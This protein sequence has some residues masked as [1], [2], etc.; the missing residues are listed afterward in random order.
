MALTSNQQLRYNRHLIH[1]GIGE[2]GQERLLRAK[3]L[4]VGVGGLGSPIALY[5]AAAGVG[6]LGLVDGDT[7]SISNLQ[8]QVLYT[9]A[10]VGKPKT[11]CAAQ[12]LRSLN[13]DVTVNTYQCM[14]TAENAEEIIK[15][16]D[17][18][19]DGTDNFDVR[20]LISDTCERLSKPYV[21]GAIRAMEGQVA[22]LCK[23]KATYRTLM[24]AE[25]VTEEMSNPD[26]S[27]V[28]TT[29]AIVGSIEA[30]QVIQLI[31]G[32]GDPL[33]DRLCTIDLST[34][35]SFIINL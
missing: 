31:C 11:L 2:E 6:T 10:E 27:V 15:E 26:K 28:G 25:E 30:S 12:R 32:F 22:V 21:Y 19:V 18:V 24:G 16:Y 13:S 20:F 23:G 33:I 29:P 1:E 7:V 35:N 5:L 4:I 34:L 17:I 8:R 14:L 3:V 9:E